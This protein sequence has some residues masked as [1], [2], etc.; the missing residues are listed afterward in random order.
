MN[1]LFLLHTKRWVFHFVGADLSAEPV[2]ALIP[3]P[4][5]AEH[6]LPLAVKLAV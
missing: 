2:V 4:I 1:I 5:F 6:E 3:A